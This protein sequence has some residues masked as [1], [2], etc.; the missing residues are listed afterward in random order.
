[1][2]VLVGGD[3][4]DAVVWAPG[5]AVGA[6]RGRRPVEGYRRPRPA[7]VP[8]LAERRLVRPAACRVARPVVRWP[9]LVVVGVAVAAVLLFAGG[10]IASMVGGMAADVPH[11]TA[12]V[13]VAPGESLWDVARQYAPESDPQAVVSRIE[14]LNGVNA[15]GVSPGAT[16]VVP[17]QSESAVRG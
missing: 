15:G 3:A 5:G 13:A 10:V 6:R 4:R 17:A 9:V 1:M 16:L 7:V 14:E 2:T 8:G 11:T 12:V